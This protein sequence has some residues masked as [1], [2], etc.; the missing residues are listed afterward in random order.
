MLGRGV[1]RGG[2]AAAA[3]AAVRERANSRGLTAPR[4]PSWLGL[5]LGLG[6]G[7]RK[8]TGLG[9][10]LGTGFGLGLLG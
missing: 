3:E 8:G 10:G 4:E 1:A 7:K 9:I 2:S 5:G 6:L